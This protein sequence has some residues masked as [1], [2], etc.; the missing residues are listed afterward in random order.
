MGP[1]GPPSTMQQLQEQELL[2]ELQDQEEPGANPGS[3]IGTILSMG[4]HVYLGLFIFTKIFGKMVSPNN[5]AEQQ[6]GVDMASLK[7]TFFTILLF[8]SE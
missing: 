1:L 3:I 7:I 8:L 5:D 4:V 2:K 6:Q